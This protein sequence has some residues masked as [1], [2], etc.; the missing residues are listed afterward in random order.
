[1][2]VARKVVAG[3]GYYATSITPA[4]IG[5]GNQTLTTQA[6]LAYSAGA[7][8]RASSQAN[9]ANYMEGLVVSYSGTTLVID[10]DNTSGSGAHSDWDIN[11]AGD[12]GS[13]STITRW[14]LMY[15]A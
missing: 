7:R 11:V 10:V 15:G 13:G 1:M 9:T 5:L 2:P 8:A 3:P 4:T 12:P 14:R 6:G